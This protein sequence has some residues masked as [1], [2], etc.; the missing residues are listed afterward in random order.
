MSGRILFLVPA[1]GGSK[2]VPGKNLRE[3]GGIPLVGRAARTALAAARALDGGAHAVACSTDDDA[4]AAA[5]AAWG[6]EV[7]RRPAELATDTATSA[8]VALHALEAAG[9]PFE[10]LVLLQ[11]TSP[12]CDP[13]GVVAAVRRHRAEGRPSVT[14]VV[15]THPA[16]W[17]QGLAADGHLSAAGPVDHDD[18]MLAGAFY[19]ISP[20]ELRETGRFVTPG[21]TLGQAVDP[22]TAVDVDQERDLVLAEALLAARP[23][24][25]VPLGGR[26]IGQGPVF[27]IAE[28]GVNHNGDPALARHLIDAAAGAGAD[29]V[30]FQTFD[31]AALAADG[32]PTADYQRAAGV[33]ADDQRA[34]LE[35]LALP[36]DAWADLQAYARA[37]GLV[38]MSTP[39]DDGSAELLDGLGVPAFKVGSGELTN[40]PFITRLAR[41]GRPMLVSTGM[42]DMAEVAAAVDAV[43]A[44][45]D[46]PLALFHCVSSYPA[47]AADANLRAIETMRRAFG[48]PVGWSDHTRGIELAL[49]AV[50][51]GAS[52]VEKH[53]TTDR[54]LPGPDHGA[55]LEP[56]EF[57]AMIAGI[58]D[59]EA[60]M[61]DGVKAPVAAE[62]NVAAV[63]RRS[64]HWAASLPVGA[65][66]AEQDLAVLRPGTGLRPG[67]IEELVGR[68]TARAVRAGTAVSLDDVVAD[69]GAADDVAAGDAAGDAAADDPGGHS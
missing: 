17:H 53:I 14:S 50:A 49:A 12:L 2:R 54:G 51:A 27:V 67:R 6:A 41:R 4:I 68:R 16:H 25:P 44:G 13:A 7:I 11:P 64:L 35:R 10:T 15:G 37:R 52:L 1:R 63:A 23:V 59:V 58:R 9:G 66:V 60:A 39:F 36:K 24:V 32:A 34:M 33:E 69:D 3:V 18:V 62:R 56:A 42:G 40:T 48:V 28:G 55:S 38:F 30:K 47:S 45:G 43:R 57:A 31:P 61:G 5:A 19:V 21:R 26:L 65:V 8:A 46:V 20:A 29:A 22:A